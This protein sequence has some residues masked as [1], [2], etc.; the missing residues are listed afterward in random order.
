MSKMTC[1]SYIW[2]FSLWDFFVSIFF[3]CFVWRTNTLPP[4]LRSEG[5]PS[6][7]VQVRTG[8]GLGVGESLVRAFCTYEYPAGLKPSMANSSFNLT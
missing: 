6:R 1:N 8:W 5:P 4:S 3:T 2:N 7:V